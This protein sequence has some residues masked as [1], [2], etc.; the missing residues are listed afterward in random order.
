MTNL[1]WNAAARLLDVDVLPTHAP[2][3]T[4]GAPAPLPS[5]GHHHD[6][7]E[8]LREQLN[9]RIKQNRYY[10]LRAFARD[11]QLAPSRISEVLNRKQG[12]SAKAAQKIANRLRLAE[13]D[14]AYFIDLVVSEHAR[15]PRD[16]EAAKIRLI[17]THL[18]GLQ[19]SQAQEEAIHET[20]VRL[21]L[22]TQPT[23]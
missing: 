6:Y 1:H 5:L 20:R 2:H 15:S 19:H 10:S 12:L 9:R 23:H 22:A 8:I 21:Q 7:R 4:S 16:R 17:Q 14:S 3:L 18:R 13:S 11:L